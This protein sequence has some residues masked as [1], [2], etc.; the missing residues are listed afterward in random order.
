M[1]TKATNA[2]FGGCQSESVKAQSGASSLENFENAHLLF[3]EAILG[4]NCVQ[5]ATVFSYPTSVYLHNW[6]RTSIILFNSLTF[7]AFIN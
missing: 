3:G 1:C 4:C 6:T 5:G 7:M 2:V